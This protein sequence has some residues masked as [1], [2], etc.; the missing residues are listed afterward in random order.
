MQVTRKINGTS[1]YLLDLGLGFFHSLFQ[2]QVFVLR[3]LT[4]WHCFFWH[5]YN[6]NVFHIPRSIYRKL[7]FFFTI[8]VDV[9][10][11]FWQILI[12]KKSSLTLSVFPNHKGW[13]LFDYA[14]HWYLSVL[15]HLLHNI[16]LNVLVCFSFF[17]HRK[18]TIR[19]CTV[20]NLMNSIDSIETIEIYL[21]ANSSWYH[22]N[23]IFSCE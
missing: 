1:W 9:Q 20:S 6:T 19:G 15:L 22:L 2:S 7:H 13:H 5:S 18:S 12:K 14:L 3:K 10:Q 23:N 17:Y 4:S 8:I 11:L 16:I 21:V